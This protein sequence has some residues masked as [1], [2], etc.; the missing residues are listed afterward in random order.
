M[1]EE[2]PARKPK[3]ADERLIHRVF[4][5]DPPQ[6][7]MSGSRKRDILLPRLC[8]DDQ[9]AKLQEQ[10]GYWDRRDTQRNAILTDACSANRTMGLNNP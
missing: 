2:A 5:Q 3:P 10:I 6:A 9:V 1:D 8:M 4:Q 7:D